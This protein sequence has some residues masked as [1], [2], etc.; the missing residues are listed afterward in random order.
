[1]L[2]LIMLSINCESKKEHSKKTN[3]PSVNKPN[4][5][6]I[7]ADD[8]GYGDLGCYGQNKIE[9]PNIDQLAFEGIK[10]TQHYSGS[11]VCAP[12]RSS[13]MTGQHTGH[14]PI[15]G[16]KELKG[17]EG[18]TPLPADA[19]TMAEVLKQ[20]GY[21]T[22]GFGKWGL[23]YIGSE[24]DPNNQGF[25]EF[26]G[27][28]CQRMAH[29]YYPPYLWRNR[30]KDSLEGNNWIDTVTYA[31][32]KIQE[33]TLRFIEHN[34]G[35]P[36]FAYVPIVLPHAELISPNDSILKKYLGKFK[37]TPYRVAKSS[38]YG[39][40][41]VLSRYCSQD[42]PYA[43]FASMVSRTDA[44]VGQIVKKVKDLGLEENTI[45]MFSSD[46]GPHVEGGADPEFFNS[47]GGL[48]GV[49]RDLYEGGIRVPFIA[50]WPNKIKA[51]TIT[52]QPSAFWDILPT[53]S[54]LVG[55]Q[56]DESDGVSLLPTLLGE[57]HQKQ[58]NYL[59]WE[60]SAKGGRKAIRKGD[61]KGVWYDVNKSNGGSFQLFNIAKDEK[62]IHD[63][64]SKHPEIVNELK[65][66]MA[67]ARTESELF[68][69]YPKK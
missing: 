46:N 51:N 7:L 59:Y 49:K 60:F 58:H 36:F 35:K 20:A 56:V 29:R 69:F 27:Y 18:Q 5:I 66:L 4:I 28:N 14:T 34:K 24:G 43:V 40:D 47:T 52:T 21:T 3:T 64:A 67:E 41:L 65:T 63:L 12:S 2:S 48:K 26:Y 37:E 38:D 10:F 50:K 61:W 53:I 45:I 13:L 57:N 33:E 32:D 42:T 54:D 16:N 19:L 17:R 62:E 25:D 55:S 31:P 44:Y 30:E 39:P 11:T 23:G 68:P 15:R 1:M 22:G 9:T 8:L 6:Y